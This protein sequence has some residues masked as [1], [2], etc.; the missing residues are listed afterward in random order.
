MTIYQF[1]IIKRW[2]QR[3]EDAKT[4]DEIDTITYAMAYDERVNNVNYCKLFDFAQRRRCKL[5]GVAVV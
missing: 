4:K 5:V 2:K 1:L 3:I